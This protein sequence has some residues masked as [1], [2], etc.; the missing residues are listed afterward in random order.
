MAGYS[1][2]EWTDFGIAAAGFSATLAGLVFVAISINIKQ[3]LQFPALPLYAAQTLI[4]FATPLVGSI[5]LIA[6]GQSRT[7]LAWE[8]IVT[9]ALVGTVQQI[10][11][12]RSPRV[13]DWETKLSWLALRV[14]PPVVSSGCLVVAGSTLLAQAGG[15]LYW[16]LPSVLAA[17][18]SGLVNAWV[19]LL[20]ILR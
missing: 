18:I 2:S 4:L 13:K 6:P 8:L 16:L 11:G 19:L 10:L 15:G 1:A 12:A 20:E 9:G 17:I 7:A 3:I 5:F 14:M